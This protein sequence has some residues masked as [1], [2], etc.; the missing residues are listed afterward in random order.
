MLITKRKKK[1]QQKCLNR[2]IKIN[3]VNYKIQSKF[4]SL[5]TF[6]NRQYKKYV[7]K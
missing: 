7:K 2:C 3:N 6:V 4:V 5:N 1:K